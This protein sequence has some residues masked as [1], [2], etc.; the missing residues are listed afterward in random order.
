MAI[1][2]KRIK[3]P[4]KKMRGV[5]DYSIELIENLKIRYSSVIPHHLV[6]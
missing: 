3:S 5:N 4:C 2:N 1:K 6:L